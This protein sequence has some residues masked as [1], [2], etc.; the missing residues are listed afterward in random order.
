MEP[1]S[2]VFKNIFSKL[3]ECFQKN[4]SVLST[5]SQVVSPQVAILLKLDF[6]TDVLAGGFHS[7]KAFCKYAL[8]NVYDLVN[9]L[10]VTLCC[11]VKIQ[12]HLSRI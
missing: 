5:F 1:A 4:R 12:R 6:I 10:Y 7:F 2:G 3:L 8:G 11:F 9:V